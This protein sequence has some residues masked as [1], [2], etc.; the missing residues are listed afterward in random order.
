MNQHCRVMGCRRETHR[1]GGGYCQKYQTQRAQTGTAYTQNLR[2]RERSPYILATLLFLNGR[3]RHGDQDVL[4]MLREVENLM[5][6]AR[7]LEPWSIHRRTP[8]TVRAQNILSMIHQQGR[9]SALHVLSAALGTEVLLR[10]RP[11]TNSAPDFRK[12]QVARAVYHLM[13]CTK[14]VYEV[15]SQRMRG[16][17][18]RTVM[19][20]RDKAL[21]SLYVSRY[22]RR[23]LEP[24]YR[25]FLA[26][27]FG[28]LQ[29]FTKRRMAKGYKYQQ[30]FAWHLYAQRHKEKLAVKYRA[31]DERAKAKQRALHNQ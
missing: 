5:K 15:E 23:L 22:L 4:M 29:T 24:T 17:V 10:M 16:S 18:V 19:K 26:D 7:A 25:L 2:P 1:W 28:E 14:K 27:R 3:V 21:N 8:N 9:Y 31:R 13:G 11:D 12:V 30:P 20:K 6:R